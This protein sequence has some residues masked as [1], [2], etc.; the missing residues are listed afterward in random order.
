MGYRV[1]I[2]T[3][4]GPG[5]DLEDGLPGAEIVCHRAPA[6]TIFENIYLNGD[7]KQILHQRADVLTCEHI[8]FSWRMAPMVYIGSIDQEIDPSVFECFSKDSLI[9]VMPQGFFRRWDEKGRISFSPWNPPEALLRRINLLVISELDVPD[10]DRVVRDW[11]N[12]VERIVVTHAARGATAYENG[13]CCHYP[14]RP[15]EEVDPTGAGDVF[16]A[17][18]LIHLAETGDTCRAA[19]FAN[20]VASFSIEKPGVAGIPLRQVVDAYLR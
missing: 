20:A 11:E 5:L 9:A 19:A 12:S 1:G 7:R 8:P 15:A 10:P 14:A 3:S 6:T 4:A 17:G 18:F 2:V 16:A 13:D